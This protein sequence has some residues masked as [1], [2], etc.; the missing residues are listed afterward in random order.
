MT[1]RAR[2]LITALAFAAS[3]VA[4]QSSRASEPENGKEPWQW[5]IS[6]GNL[7]I[8]NGSGTGKS[9]PVGYERIEYDGDVDYVGLTCNGRGV[10]AASIQFTHATGDIDM[11]VY[12]IGGNYLGRSQGITDQERVDVSAFG[13]QLV[14]VKAYGYNGAINDYGI[15]VE[16]N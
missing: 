10:K 4:S 15:T 11:Y 5:W 7:T 2:Q 9:W 13:K 8:Y 6:T 12:D 14:I 3:F 16:C 1:I